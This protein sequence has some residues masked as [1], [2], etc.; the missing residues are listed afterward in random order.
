[1]SEYQKSFDTTIY[2]K[3]GNFGE[4]GYEVIDK[5]SDIGVKGFYKF[6]KNQNLIF[7][8]FL[9]SDSNEYNFSIEYDKFGSEIKTTGNEVIQWYFRKVNS[10]SIRATFFLYTIN[11][12]YQNIKVIADRTH[13]V[14][15]VESPI[16]S[17]IIGGAFYFR[18]KDITREKIYIEGQ[19]INVCNQSKI[20][21]KDS[22]FIP[23]SLF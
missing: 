15:L 13:K 7:Y 10:D 17:N 18:L 16:F 4:K 3:K 12:K 8:A 23:R 1:M 9:L 6:D 22:A 20:E 14:D 19:R 2:N 11:R 5:G 21:F